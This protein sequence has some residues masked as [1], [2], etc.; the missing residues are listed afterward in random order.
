MTDF[1]CFKSDKKDEERKFEFSSRLYT[2]SIVFHTGCLVH[3]NKKSGFCVVAPI[4]ASN[5]QFSDDHTPR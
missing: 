5:S 2:C 1:Y 4:A 3:V